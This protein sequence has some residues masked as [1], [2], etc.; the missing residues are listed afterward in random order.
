MLECNN[1]QYL[2]ETMTAKVRQGIPTR[3]LEIC[4]IHY[5]GR[6]VRGT[7]NEYYSQIPKD[8][9]FHSSKVSYCKMLLYNATLTQFYNVLF[10][11]KLH[12]LKRERKTDFTEVT[13]RKVHLKE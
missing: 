13:I 8:Q 4:Y 6:K 11:I 3:R 9:V 2:E 12:L 7:G 1:T 5:L 10:T